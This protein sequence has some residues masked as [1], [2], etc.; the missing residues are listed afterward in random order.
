MS[1]G[2]T[3][4]VV[5]S[6]VD[7]KLSHAKPGPRVFREAFRLLHSDVRQLGASGLRSL[8]HRPSCP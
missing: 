3:V 8:W 5:E 7:V 2:A 1:V 6:G 4:C